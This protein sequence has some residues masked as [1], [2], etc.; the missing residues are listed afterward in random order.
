MSGF[1][2]AII[3]MGFVSCA[4]E[5]CSLSEPSMVSF[6]V[7]GSWLSWRCCVVGGV[8]GMTGMIVALFLSLGC[9]VAG[10][11]FSPRMMMVVTRFGF[12]DFGSR[13]VAV[14]FSPAASFWGSVALVAAFFLSSLVSQGFFVNLLILAWP[15]LEMVLLS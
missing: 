12:S 3:M 9:V 15:R 14:V 10:F 5:G 6:V 11:S 13:F 4:S 1:A 7:V 8:E 2:G